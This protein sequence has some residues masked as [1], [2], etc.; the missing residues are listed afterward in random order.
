MYFSKGGILRIT[1]DIEANGLLDETTV[2]YLSSPYKLKD[3]FKIW[4]IVC[5]DIDT[6]EIHKF[7]L[8]DV[9]TKF[10]EFSKQIKTLI[11][12]NGIDY[13]LLVLKL[14]LLQLYLRNPFLLHMLHMDHYLNRNK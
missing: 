3:T 5:Q 4:C 10:P 2:D 12:H 13:D 1:L 11:V 8:D 9:Y 14:A 6:K 7:V